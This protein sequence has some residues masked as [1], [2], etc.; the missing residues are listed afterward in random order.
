MFEYSASGI[1]P[2][3][4]FFDID[5]EGRLHSVKFEG[6]GCSGNLK[7]IPKLCEGMPA[8][9]VMNNIK[10]IACGSKPTSCGDQF[11]RAIEK[12]LEHINQTQT[13]S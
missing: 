8:S 1:C 3:K 5:D 6:G 4:I 7:V 9:N 11:A 12:A 13:H 10:G 2:D